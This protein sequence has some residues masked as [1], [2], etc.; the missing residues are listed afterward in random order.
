MGETAVLSASLEVINLK[1]Q[2]VRVIRIPGVITC[3]YRHKSS[4]YFTNQIPVPGKA[5]F[6]LRRVSV[7]CSNDNEA[8][9]W[10]IT[11]KSLHAL[12]PNLFGMK[13]AVLYNNTF[14]FILTCIKCKID[15]Y[16]ACNKEY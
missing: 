10:I 12:P 1:G 8:R 3:R 6:I 5:H 15:T 16:R 13:S 9:K 2:T 4:V 7:N 11:S 14:L